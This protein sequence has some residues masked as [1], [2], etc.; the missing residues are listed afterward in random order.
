MEKYGHALSLLNDPAKV[1]LTALGRQIATLGLR[2]RFVSRLKVCRATRAT[3]RAPCIEGARKF[4]WC[5]RKLYISLPAD[6]I[7]LCVAR[8]A[9]NMKAKVA[10]P[11]T[12]QPT[13]SALHL[14]PHSSLSLLG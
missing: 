13:S 3:H 4:G 2:N 6:V 5:E 12:K 14:T 10:C 9:I 7:R 8:P 1:R 11:N